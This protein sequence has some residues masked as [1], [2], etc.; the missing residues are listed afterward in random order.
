MTLPAPAGFS[1][2]LAYVRIAEVLSRYVSRIMVQATLARALEEHGAI[3]HSLRPREAKAIVE[4]AMVS[5]RLFCPPDRLSDLMLALA[6]VC[7]E[8]EQGESRA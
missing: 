6:D 4:H 1:G 7:D 8:L 2:S 3:A 5:L